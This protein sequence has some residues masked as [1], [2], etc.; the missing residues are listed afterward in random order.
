MPLRRWIRPWCVG[1]VAEDGGRYR[2]FIDEVST[3]VYVDIRRR[4]LS[5]GPA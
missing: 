2:V 3:S 5:G 1:Y 4:L